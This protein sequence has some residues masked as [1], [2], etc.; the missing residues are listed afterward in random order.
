MILK[1]LVKRTKEVSRQTLLKLQICQ[2][3]F[4]RNFN[5]I[6]PFRIVGGRNDGE[7]MPGHCVVLYGKTLYSHSAS[8]NPGV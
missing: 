8:L 2:T 5:L 6:I 1:E 3:W 7:A 4:K